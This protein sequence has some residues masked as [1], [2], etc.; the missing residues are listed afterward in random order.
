MQ[1]PGSKD[2]GGG[3]VLKSVNKSTLQ[4]KKSRNRRSGSPINWTPRK[5]TESFIKRKI[6]HLQVFDEGLMCASHWSVNG[7]FHFFLLPFIA[8]Q[9]NKSAI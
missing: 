3:S 8:L 9:D 6:K 5:K 7:D 2:F 4:F 1:S